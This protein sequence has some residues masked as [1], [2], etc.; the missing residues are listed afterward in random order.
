[1]FSVV[2]QINDSAMNMTTVIVQTNAKAVGSRH[3]LC[4]KE[5]LQQ[6]V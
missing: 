6:I 1:M 3:E 5:L 4:V 2:A